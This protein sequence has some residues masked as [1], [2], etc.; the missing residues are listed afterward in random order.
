MKKGKHGIKGDGDITKEE[1]LTTFQ[2]FVL[3]QTRK[4]VH[5]VMADGVSNFRWLRFDSSLF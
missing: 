2:Q 3:E 4:G 5:F 1:N